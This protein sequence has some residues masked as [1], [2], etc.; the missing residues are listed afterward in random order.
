M[1]LTRSAAYGLHALT[2]L[3]SNGGEHPVAAHAIAQARGIPHLPLLKVLHA[4]VAARLLR[5]NRGLHGGYRL[6][7]PPSA[8]TMLE[9]V[10]A[11]DGPLGDRH[12]PLSGA[13]GP[14]DRRIQSAYERSTEAVRGVLGKVRMS[15]LITR[16]K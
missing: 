15:D 13:G 8:I 16:K 2:F 5:S 4:L 1:R 9:V 7:R 11:V 6:A 12:Q 14:L 10:Q 3:A